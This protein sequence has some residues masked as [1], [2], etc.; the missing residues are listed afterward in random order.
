MVEDD[1]DVSFAACGAGGCYGLAVLPKREAGADQLFEFYLGR[2]AE[3]QGEAGR[4]FSL[5]L[6]GAVSVAA[7]EVDFFVPERG[8]VEAAF[9]GW[10]PD[11]RRLCARLCETNGVLHR[12]GRADAVVYAV[13]TAHYY[14]LS[15]LRFV[16]LCAQHF[17]QLG[18]GLLRTY[19][20]VGTE[21]E[22]F[23][24]LAGVLGDADDAAGFGEVS[25]RGDGEKANAACPNDQARIARGG[26]E[27]GVHGAGEGF[28]GDGGLV[29]DG[30]GYAVELRRVGDE[31][32]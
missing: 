19:D 12:G 29:G 25:Q 14:G 24:S 11:E 13:G 4:L 10:H 8:E 30:V 28:D 15:K 16:R 2:E 1:F 22:R 17:R 9:R 21:A 5:V 7:G 23:L 18:V 3:R 20:L 26:L 31:R 27:R 6:F 32:P